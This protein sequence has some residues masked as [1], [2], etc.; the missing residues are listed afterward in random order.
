MRKGER[1]KISS[2]LFIYSF[3]FVFSLFLGAYNVEPLSDLSW[4]VLSYG[5]NLAYHF[6]VLQAFALVSIVYIFLFLFLLK[7]KRK[8]RKWKVNRKLF[9]NVRFYFFL[10]FKFQPA[11]VNLN[12]ML[13]PAILDPFQG[14]NYRVWATIHQFLLCPILCK[15]FCYVSNYLLTQFPVTRV[16]KTLDH[17]IERNID[18][19]LIKISNNLVNND[20]Y[21]NTI[22]NLTENGH[23]HVD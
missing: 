17:P 21:N 9:S 1:F 6:W 16:K 2:S 15:S 5:L 14:Q 13:C 10:I 23:T 7:T 3:H 12:H 18:D 22:N 20:S 4:S 8:E 11:Q 19:S